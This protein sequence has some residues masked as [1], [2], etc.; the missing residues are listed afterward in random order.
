MN[1]CL[2]SAMHLNSS[3]DLLQCTHAALQAHASVQCSSNV[4]MSSLADVINVYLVHHGVH[5]CTALEQHHNNVLFLGL[6][7]RKQ[8][9]ASRQHVTA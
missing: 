3:T 1:D 2:G 5:I 9:C 4:W 6:H 8:G 7:C